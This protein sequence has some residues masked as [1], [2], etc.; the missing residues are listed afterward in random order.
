[1]GLRK[2][3]VARRVWRAVVCVCAAVALVGALYGVASKGRLQAHPSSTVTSAGVRPALGTPRSKEAAAAAEMPPAAGAG[4]EATVGDAPV[5]LAS[6]LLLAL[7]GGQGQGLEVTGMKPLMRFKG[8][9]DG[10]A[11]LRPK[12]GGQEAVS[13]FCL[14]A[15]RQYILDA[16]FM[17]GGQV[18][19]V[20]G[21]ADARK[22]A[23][24]VTSRARPGLPEVPLSEHSP[25]RP[26]G[27]HWFRAFEW[28]GRSGDAFTGASVEITVEEGSG[29]LLSYREHRPP[30]RVP[31]PQLTA[32]AAGEAAVR[33]K[34]G[35]RPWKYENATLVLSYPW[36]PDDGPVWEVA[37]SPPSHH[38]GVFDYGGMIIDAVKGTRVDDPGTSLGSTG[39]SDKP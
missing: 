24:E 13:D 25:Q 11:R 9:W 10:V 19:E 7:L 5:A 16:G 38:P 33:A 20:T 21:T 3:R 36:A 32:E 14:D 2:A 34:G 31:A 6:R 4:A 1:M 12:D 23:L 30:D 37:M 35:R 15:D 28:L 26:P 27:T 18:P 8:R 17:R 29:W 22:V 39:D